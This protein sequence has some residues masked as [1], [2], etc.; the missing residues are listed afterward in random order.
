ME[1]NGTIFDEDSA[2]TN[3]ILFYVLYSDK[4]STIVIPM[5]DYTCSFESEMIDIRDYTNQSKVTEN[6]PT[7]GYT[8]LFES[9]S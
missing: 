7:R 5:N 9:V 2:Y 1:Q 8:R 6:D 4:I 3:A